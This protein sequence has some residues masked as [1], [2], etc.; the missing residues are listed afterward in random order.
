MKSAN[1][2][3]FLQLPGTLPDKA[4]EQKARGYDVCICK[5]VTYLILF[6]RVPNVIKSGQLM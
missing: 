2:P 3:L 4:T 6:P 5:D 1:F